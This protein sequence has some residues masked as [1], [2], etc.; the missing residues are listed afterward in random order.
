MKWKYILRI[1]L[2]GVLLY[3]SIVYLDGVTLTA[4]KYGIIPSF[5]LLLAIFAVVEVLL[6]PIMKMLI[7]P[8]RIITFGFASAVL[9][10]NLVYIIALMYP[11]F[12]ISSFWHALLFGVAL[13]IVRLLTK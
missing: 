5:V 11:F 1:A 10:V 12:E 9:S 4:T 6:Y 7:L 2:I 3:L 13:G 8:L